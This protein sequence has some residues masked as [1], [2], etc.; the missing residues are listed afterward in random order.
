VHYHIDLLLL[1]SEK[2]QMGLQYKLALV[3]DYAQDDCNR[4]AVL[5]T[6]AR[7]EIAS[8]VVTTRTFCCREFN[9]HSDV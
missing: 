1:M 4:Y 3:M 2:L 6:L 5:L 9:L 8:R 7:V